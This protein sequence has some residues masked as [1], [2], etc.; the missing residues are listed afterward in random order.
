MG[1]YPLLLVPAG[2]Y[3]REIRSRPM[4]FVLC[5]ERLAHAILDAVEKRLWFPPKFGLD[6]CIS[7]LFFA[8]D[9]ILFVE[10]SIS[11]AEVIA[12]IL[13]DFCEHS[14]HRTSYVR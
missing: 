12:N 1:R 6:V 2:E 4:F 10:A 7:H 13:H 3:A 8:D 5:M 11:K 14:E 9:L